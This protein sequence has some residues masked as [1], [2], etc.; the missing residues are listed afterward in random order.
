MA[1]ESLSFRHN[2]HMGDIPHRWVP[3][4]HLYDPDLP[5]F[6]IY[7]FHVLNPGIQ[8][9]ARPTREDRAFGY[10]E[11]IR[12]RE[13][14]GIDVG[15]V[16][17]KNL[18]LGT[19]SGYREAVEREV[20]SRFGINDP[21]KHSD[22]SSAF[23][24]PNESANHVLSELWHRVVANA[25]GN[26]L[27][28]GRLWDEVLGLARFVASWNP[29]SGRKGELIMTHYFA[30]RF[31]ERVQAA[32]GIPQLDFFLL[33]TVVELLDESN[34]LTDF[35]RYRDLVLVADQFAG[36]NG[37]EVDVDGVRLTGFRSRPG[38]GRLDRAKFSA[39]LERDIDS[40]L[41]PTAIECN[42]TFDKNSQR[43]V[44]FLL[45]LDDIRKGR[46]KPE[47]LT[48]SQCGSIY[49]GLKGSYQAPKVIQ[50]YAQQ[51]FGNRDAFPID[52]WMESLMRWPLSVWPRTRIRNPARTVFMGTRGLG[53]VE[54]LLWVTSQSRKVHSSAC[55]DAVWC[56]KYGADTGAG[57]DDR[58]PRGANPFACNICLAAVR[59]KCPAFAEI[60]NKTV[61]FNGA[62]PTAD[63]QVT[64]SNG[65]NT[66][67]NQSFTECTGFSIYSRVVDRFSPS[68][69][70][71]GF[72]PF[73]AVGHDG[74]ELTV[75]DF[76][77]RY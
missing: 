15:L 5:L 30:T 36:L 34:P 27:P 25:Y 62:S 38:E 42:N 20:R 68:D 77:D 16:T 67:A 74:A 45:M 7:Y 65:D 76:V 64:T 19:N 61:G 35:G 1:F 22:V 66:R 6:P 37:E 18:S 4:I 9:P 48:S 12:V 28:F 57:G 72:R 53:K 59:Q 10:V 33:P 39:I 49:E 60:K 17:N 50:I 29:P 55:D 70:P 11:H 51:C 32:S 56:I 31:G 54:R 43:T 69:C 47:S 24:A 14:G 2:F 13:E 63:F 75:Q 23:E 40:P 58:E 26:L 73:P 3:L 41:Q 44:I 8:S 46:L 52:T 21:V 71:E